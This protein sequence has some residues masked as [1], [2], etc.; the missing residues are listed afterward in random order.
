[1]VTETKGHESRAEHVGSICGGMG[2]VGW[3]AGGVGCVIGVTVVGKEDDRKKGEKG[4]KTKYDSLKCP[5]YTDYK[6]YKVCK[7]YNG[8]DA[9]GTDYTDSNDYKGTDY[10]GLIMAFYAT[11]NPEMLHKVTRLVDSHS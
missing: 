11:H 9:K 5:D 6:D 8:G 4:E 1:M 2:D 3:V 7:D 10:K